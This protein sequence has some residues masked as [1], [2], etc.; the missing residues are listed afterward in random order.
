MG[1]GYH[2][3]L[4][5]LNGGYNMGKITVKCENCGKK[6]IDYESNH[7][8]FCCR[9]CKNEYQSKICDD[10]KIK[11]CKGCGK[12]FRPKENRTQ[13]CSYACYNEY[14]N[15][16]SYTKVARKCKWCGEEF[17]PNQYKKQ[18]CSKECGYKWYSEYKKTDEQIRLQTEKVLKTI[19]DGRMKKS[20]TKPHLIIDKVLNKLG[21]ECIN[22][23]NINYYSIDIYLPDSNLM[24]EVMGDYWHSNPISKYKECKSV[25]QQKTKNRDK[26]KHTYVKNQYGIEILYL[27]ESDIEYEADMCEELIKRY[28]E[29]NGILEDYNSYNYILKHEGLVLKE[30]IVQPLFLLNED[31]VA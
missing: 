11:K 4:L 30:N 2:V 22:E 29:N 21:M 3:F 5:C 15:R 24:I 26:R 31:D 18:F 25:P 20:F 9:D 23:Y 14:I 13:F 27:W 12:T 7:R 6:F 10:H 16:I 8:R 28:V 19:E 17:Y 1:L